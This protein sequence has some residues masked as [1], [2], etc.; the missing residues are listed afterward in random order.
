MT[1]SASSSGADLALRARAALELR[2]RQAANG[3]QPPPSLAALVEATTQLT[4]E[5]W[6][7]IVCRRLEHLVSQTGQRLLIHGPPQYGKSLII[8][9]RFPAYALGIKPVHRLRVACYNVTHAERFSKVNLDLLRDPAYAALFP[10]PGVRVPKIAPVEEWS[11][12]ARAAKRDANPSFKAL[13]LGTGFTGLG[14]DILIIDD[15]YKNAQ[16]ARSEAINARLWEWW[17]QVVLSRLNPQTNI[18]VMFHRWWE[19]DFAGRLI[20]QGGWEQLR[21][22]AIAD[23]KPDDPT[24]RVAGEVLSPRYPRAYLDDLRRTMGTAF[25][26]LYQGMPFPAGGSLF[27]A[28][29]VGFLDAVPAQVVA[30]VRRWDI[31]ATVNAGDHSCGVL[32]ARLL[33]GRTLVEDVVRGQWGPD[34]RNSIIRETAERD[35]RR[36]PVTHVLPQEPGAAGVDLAQAFVRLLSGFSVLTE[37]ETGSKEVRADPWAS[38]WNAG[39]VV[40][41]RAAWNEA[42]LT[43]H[44]A[45]PQGTFDDQVDG[46]SGAFNRLARRT[47]EPSS[48][49]TGAT[50]TTW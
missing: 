22:P 13:G 33:D 47:T 25:E 42:Y 19:N 24:G 36:G 9:Q 31:A 5:P 35:A 18:V 45:F 32:L 49:P 2:R 1:W 6:Q 23:G 41:L 21:F 39:N 37:R 38:Q 17:T 29:K 40:L 46:S 8:S 10:D 34:E 28:G 26:A 16:E 14:V 15:P 4:L 20:A 3:D 43:E 50:Y 11:T 30:R 12:A 44:Y 48:R 7:Q 27:K